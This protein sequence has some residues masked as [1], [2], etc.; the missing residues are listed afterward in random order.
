M[1]DH[2]SVTMFPRPAHDPCPIREK[3]A[4]AVRQSHF[5]M[6]QLSAWEVGAVTRSDTTALAEIEAQL[7]SA[8]RNHDADLTTFKNHIEA[9]RCLLRVW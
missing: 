9:H 7:R 5:E 3:I 8:R 1:L 2:G 6:V 4:E